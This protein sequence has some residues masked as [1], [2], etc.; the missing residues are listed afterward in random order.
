MLIS[1][2]PF[3]AVSASQDQANDQTRRMIRQ[4]MLDERIPGLQLA[5]V[6]DGQIVLSEA[7]GLANVENGVLVS[8]DT[9]FP[10]N[11]ATKAFTGVAIAQLAEQGRLDLE[12]PA[13]RY[14][15]D[16]PAAWQDVR[17]RQLLAHTSGLP[18][19]LDANGLLGGGSEA[20]AW[21]AVTARPVEAAPGQRF[22]YNQTNYVLL[23]RIIA[24]QSG[25]PFE[26]YLATGQFSGARMARTTFGDS[27]DL[28]PDVATMYSLAPRATD[29]AGMPPRLSHWFYDMPP[30][31]WAGGGILTTADDTARWL[32]ALTE[33]RLLQDASR[34]RMWTAERLAEG[35]S[36]PWAGGWPVLNASPDLQVAGIGG[37][38][39]AFVV[40]PERGV[41]VV[42][43]TNLVGANPQRFI[44]RIADFYAPA[45]ANTAPTRAAP[46]SPA[47]SPR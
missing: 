7:Y 20:Q 22:A 23:A 38:R 10:L 3:T 25:M 32:V 18:D 26:R 29:A 1:A 35:R 19:I 40:Y 39:S 30:G 2:L 12:A 37:A 33:G 4:L 28:I 13:S 9:R 36:G 21:A 43:L 17:V 16:L 15:H 6:K 11:S 45:A 44:P 27:Y 5:V 8:R 41:A 46:P 34:Q 24:Q 31:L 42:M 14:L 47:G